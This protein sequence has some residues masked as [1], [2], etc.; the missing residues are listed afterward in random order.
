MNNVTGLTHGYQ[1]MTCKYEQCDRVNTWL[2]AD[3][4]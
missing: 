2:P 4:L 3:D 1:L